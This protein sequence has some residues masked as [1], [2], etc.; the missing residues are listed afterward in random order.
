MEVGQNEPQKAGGGGLGC[1]RGGQQGS[2]ARRGGPGA[3]RKEV[4]GDAG[5]QG[6]ELWDPSGPR[7]LFYFAEAQGVHL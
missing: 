1:R 2:Q 6:R 7:S 5:E 4:P 3:G